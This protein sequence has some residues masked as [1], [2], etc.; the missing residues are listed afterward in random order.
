MDTGGLM[1]IFGMIGDLDHAFCSPYIFRTR[2]QRVAALVSQIQSTVRRASLSTY[3]APLC[4]GA[5]C[6]VQGC[7]KVLE[8]V[9]GLRE[10]AGIPFPS[11][12]FNSRKSEIRFVTFC[13]RPG[14]PRC[15]K[16]QNGIKLRERFQSWVIKVYFLTVSNDH[17][18][19]CQ[20]LSWSVWHHTNVFQVFYAKH[21]LHLFFSLFFVLIISW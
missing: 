10:V 18:V 5:V 3:S 21:I 17:T 20:G 1:I 6:C 2:S 9:G 19:V 12:A 13:S 4:L 11:F 16:C 14:G 15:L 8:D 7:F